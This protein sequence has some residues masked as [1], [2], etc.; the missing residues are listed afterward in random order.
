M[1]VS[2]TVSEIFSIK[3]CRDLETGG[4]GRS[5][6]LEMAPFD[7]PYTTFHWSAI[8]YI[9]SSIWYY[10]FWATWRWIISW[11]WNLGYRSLKLIQNGTI[12]KLVCGFLFAF[13]S[14]DISILYQFG[15]EH[16]YWSRI[17]I[18]SYPLAFGAPVRGVAVG[19]LPSR[20][21]WKN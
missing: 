21:V 2:R 16:R 20:L 5:R 11:P 19:I 8:V 13:H 1:S 3:E 7:R 17:V 10:R 6:S 4:R 15:D 18:F 12:R 9:C 14:N